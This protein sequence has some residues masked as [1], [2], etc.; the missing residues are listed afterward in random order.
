MLYRLA[1]KFR[2]F[3][4]RPLADFSFPRWLSSLGIAAA[5]FEIAATLA[6]GGDIGRAVVPAPALLPGDFAHQLFSSYALA[7]EAVTLLMF[8]AAL[9]VL[10]DKETA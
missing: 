6:A 10:P 7:T 8:L 3:E 5:A 1:V 9:A 2:N 4:I